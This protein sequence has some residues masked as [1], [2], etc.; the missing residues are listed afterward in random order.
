MTRDRLAR[1]II[2]ELS[3]GLIFAGGLGLVV[4]ALGGAYLV[5]GGIVLGVLG[6]MLAIW[7]LFVG[8]GIEQRER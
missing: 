4:H 6:A 8:L 1:F 5:A 2:G 7:I 3:A